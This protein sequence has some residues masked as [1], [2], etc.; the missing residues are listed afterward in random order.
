MGVPVKKGG[1]GS[2][3]AKASQAQVGQNVFAP[4][5]SSSEINSLHVMSSSFRDVFNNVLP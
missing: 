1:K 3:A 5:A 4:H 2:K